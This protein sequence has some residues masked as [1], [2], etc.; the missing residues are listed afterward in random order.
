M[1]KFHCIIAVVLTVGLGVM[2]LLAQI[3]PKPG[4]PPDNRSLIP[5]F[6]AFVL[7]FIV[8]VGAMKGAKRS[9]QD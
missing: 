6:I 9:H 4:P 7:T 1:R 3:P 5:Y 8:G 2:P